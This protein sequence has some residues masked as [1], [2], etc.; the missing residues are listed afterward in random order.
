VSDWD[1]RPGWYQDPGAQWRFRWWDGGAWTAFT[2]P[3]GPP[4]GGR[5]APEAV[6]RQERLWSWAQAAVIVYVV[7]AVGTAILSVS[8]SAQWP[9]LFHW[10]RQLVAHVGT[11]GYVAPRAPALVPSWT[12]LSGL[13]AILATVLFLMWQYRAA[14][15][16]R[17]IGLPAAR[18][19]GWGVGSWFVPVVNLWMPMQALR[20]C[21][22]PGHPRRRLVWMLLFT[23]LVTSVVTAAAAPVTAYVEPV[24]MALLVVCVAG[25]ITILAIA[26]CLVRT[27]GAVQRQL[28]E[29]IEAR[30]L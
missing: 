13:P 12:I 6:A 21:L 2:A 5:F 11:P 19:P 20:D 9:K 3:A 7:Q 28:L 17:A 24:G 16:G 23:W 14:Q 15:A 22:P 29:S 25:Q 26:L 18:S 1:W 30:R 8:R 27:I 4:P 10:Y